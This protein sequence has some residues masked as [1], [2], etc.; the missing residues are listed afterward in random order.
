MPT[1]PIA[2]LLDLAKAT[3]DPRAISK[4]LIAYLGTRPYDAKI[5]ALKGLE[6]AFAGGLAGKAEP[7]AVAMV[8]GIVRRTLEQL[9]ASGAGKSRQ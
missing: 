9:Q 4:W 2:A 6:H 8:L 1:D 3:P 7:K 5:S